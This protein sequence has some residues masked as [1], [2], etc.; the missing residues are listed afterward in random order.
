VLPLAGLRYVVD[1]IR[2]PRLGINVGQDSAGV[3]VDGVVPGGPAEEAGLQPGDYLLA[4]GDV[5]INDPNAFALFRQKYGNQEGTEFPIQVRRNGQTMTLT[6]KVRLVARAEVRLE[7]DPNA[8]DK[9]R[10]VLD[11][12]TTGR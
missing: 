6:G 5:P 8:S 7:R 11:G 9:A 3:R 2:E 12:I 10:R 4:V 1:S